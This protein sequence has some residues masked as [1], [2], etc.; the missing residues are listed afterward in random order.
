[1][2]TTSGVFLRRLKPRA[3][4][5]CTMRC[6]SG[7]ARTL[8]GCAASHRSYQRRRWLVAGILWTRSSTTCACTMREGTTTTLGRGSWKC[9]SRTP[10]STSDLPEPV[11]CST[12]ARRRG[13]SGW[14]SARA[15]A[16]WS[17][18]D[19]A[20]PGSG[21]ARAPSTPSVRS[22]STTRALKPGV[23]CVTIAAPS[24]SYHS[25]ARRI[26]ATCAAM[27]RRSRS[28]SKT[29]SRAHRA[30]SVLRTARRS[31]M[32]SAERSAPSTPHA[33]VE[34]S[35][36]KKARSGAAASTSARASAKRARTTVSTARSA[37]DAR[38]LAKGRRG[39]LLGA[40]RLV[41]ERAPALAPFG[42]RAPPGPRAASASTAL[43]ANRS[44]RSRSLSRASAS[45]AAR[46]PR[47]RP[48]RRRA[49]PRRRGRR[50]RGRGARDAPRLVVG[51]AP[52][53]PRLLDAPARG[54]LV[55]VAALRGALA[56]CSARF[57][58]RRELGRLRE[59][60]RGVALALDVEALVAARAERGAR[61]RRRRSPARARA[62]ARPRARAPSKARAVA[63]CSLASAAAASL[64][65]VATRRSS[66]SR[67][68]TALAS[69]RSAR[70]DATRASRSAR[71]A[72]LRARVAASYCAP[73][74]RLQE[75][76]GVGEEGVRV[77]KWSDQRRL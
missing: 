57:S 29:R 36:R 51:A 10:R 70:S 71:S 43:A 25:S 14:S 60:A 59:H 49:S 46:R 41:R 22:T 1:M 4:T 8:A 19:A 67:S 28:S 21:H 74:M 6:R 55:G 17:M 31:A 73:V 24:S 56:S 13:V 11:G 52:H 15:V 18:S 38:R 12:S 62:R 63:A 2:P 30:S 77:A 54:R 45:L 69:A 33:S 9:A 72:A 50:R 61:P 39:R 44:W 37:A 26:C 16:W 76:G 35:A 40:A 58:S 48:P 66:A 23:P 20:C 5:T 65:A 47:P 75:G 42:A 27:A 64:V 32:G 3:A 68:A 53:A 34:S 7:S